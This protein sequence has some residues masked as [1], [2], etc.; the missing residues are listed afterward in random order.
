MQSA[1]K[2]EL[3]SN[4]SA[5]V[6]G[7]VPHLDLAES[8]EDVS[9]EDV[10]KLPNVS[11]KPLDLA[12]SHVNHRNSA[13]DAD[14]GYGVSAERAKEQLDASQIPY[15]DPSQFSKSKPLGSS[16]RSTNVA[17]RGQKKI[18]SQYADTGSIEELIDDTSIVNED[19]KSESGY[20]PGEH[21]VSV[22]Q[23]ARGARF[24]STK[25]GDASTRPGASN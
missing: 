19:L 5:R 18:D 3:S 12:N 15:V 23:G 22:G 9:V 17:A 6:T 21:Q 1:E 2:D 4:H 16:A 13:N 25:V 7:D 8:L 10:G 24:T 11:G 20:V 14:T